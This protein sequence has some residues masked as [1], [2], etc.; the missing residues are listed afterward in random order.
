MFSEIFILLLFD[1]IVILFS[2]F[3][4]TD[5]KEGTVM[6]MDKV[7]IG[8]KIRA[9]WKQLGLSQ[10]EFA[11]PIWGSEKT[12][13]SW[14]GVYLVDVVMLNTIDRKGTMPPGR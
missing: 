9:A 8:T 6:L 13:S 12:L 4:N 11:R 7:S 3:I 1:W 2:L 10:E 14:G 5:I